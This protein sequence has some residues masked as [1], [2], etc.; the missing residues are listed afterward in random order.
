[1]RLRCKKLYRL[2]GVPGAYSLTTLPP[3]EKLDYEPFEYAEK[4]TSDF[5]ISRDDDGGFDIS[6]GL[7]EELA[8]NVV[9]DSYDSFTYFQ[10]Q[11][12][13]QSFQCI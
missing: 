3:L 9:L 10:K 2:G 11:L 12:K 5:E 1:M 6:G 13:E 8:R 4:S 7:M